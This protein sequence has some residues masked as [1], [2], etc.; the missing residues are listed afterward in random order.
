M[1]GDMMM[2]DKAAMDRMIH[3]SMTRTMVMEKIK[4]MMKDMKK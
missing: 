4:M 2:K 1:A 3:E